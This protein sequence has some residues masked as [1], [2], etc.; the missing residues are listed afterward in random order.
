M[1]T[2]IKNYIEE[3]R[4]EVVERISA[5]ILRDSCYR[6]VVYWDGEE[7]RAIHGGPGHLIGI[8]KVEE[9]STI[10]FD[11]PDSQ[12]DLVEIYKEY[13]SSPG[14]VWDT[15]DREGL[16]PNQ[17]LIRKVWEFGVQSWAE[18]LALDDYD[19]PEGIREAAL[20]EWDTNNRV[21]F[22]DQWVESLLD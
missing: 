19:D 12:D 2:Q 4:Q 10:S 3:N 17:P 5:A 21:P 8:K 6:T 22:V 14:K 13:L 15:L 11:S 9:I 16:D 20:I 7:V 1:K 18:A